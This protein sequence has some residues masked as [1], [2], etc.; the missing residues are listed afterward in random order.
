MHRYDTC[1]VQKTG[2]FFFFFYT[3]TMIKI[4][5]NNNIV[6]MWAIPCAVSG[7]AY[8]KRPINLHIYFRPDDYG[9]KGG[10]RMWRDGNFT[11][12]HRRRRTSERFV[13]ITIGPAAT[14]HKLSTEH[15]GTQ[16]LKL[17][18]YAIRYKRVLCPGVS[19]CHRRW[20]A[21]QIPRVSCA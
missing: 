8:R 9:S 21:K 4:I 12:P 20:N 14:A 15:V 13:T 5:I 7:T 3:V 10:R 2:F 6:H 18:L 11:P 17:A 1:I 16:T 19:M